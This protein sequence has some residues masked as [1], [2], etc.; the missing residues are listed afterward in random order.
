MRHRLSTVKESK[1]GAS[2]PHGSMS[3]VPT[4][5]LP[6]AS[7]GSLLFEVTLLLRR[8]QHPAPPSAPA[9]SA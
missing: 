5:P 6:L 1:G 4:D 3:P 8:A 9:R 7:C 2:G